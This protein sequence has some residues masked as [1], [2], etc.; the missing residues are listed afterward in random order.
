MKKMIMIF[1]LLLFYIIGN[2]VFN[3]VFSITEMI[4]A[5][6]LSLQINF[7]DIYMKNVINNLIL[8]SSLYFIIMITI[9]SI[10]WYL[11]KE[12]NK[13]LKRRKKNEK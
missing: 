13:K 2:I 9:Y 1:K 5:N 4:V 10:N 8:Y 11:V 3:V 7:F 12:L 6:I